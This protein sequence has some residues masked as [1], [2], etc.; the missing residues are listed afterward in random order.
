M[1]RAV[2]ARRLEQVRG[3][4][5]EE[6]AQQIDRERETER[7]MRQPDRQIAT[8]DA[9]PGVEVQDR[10][11][12]QLDRHHL[13]P[14]DRQEDPVAPRELHPGK[15]VRGEGCYQNGDYR[16]W[17]GNNE[18]VQERLT[19]PLGLKHVLIILDGEVPG[20]EQSRPPASGVDGGRET[21]RADEQAK[22]GDRPEQPDQHDDD[23]QD[24]AVDRAHEALARGERLA[25]QRMR[26]ALAVGGD[27]YR[28]RCGF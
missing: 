9:H 16:S 3:Q 10:D 6:V 25:R 8:R 13:E 1:P 23:R 28:L 2:D 17:D 4:R 11:Q 24:T 22:G 19:H 14:D 21:E 12:R 27:Q 7:G 26:A 15:G 20:R 18:T 5:A